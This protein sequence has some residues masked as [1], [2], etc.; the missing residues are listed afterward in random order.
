[1]SYLYIA[2]IIGSCPLGFFIG[3]LIPKVKK[4]RWLILFSGIYFCLATYLIP[5]IIAYLGV[6]LLYIGGNL[7]GFLS[8]INIE[9]SP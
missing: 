9:R 7:L 6:V 1:M 3:R 5:G 2:F 4:I 8:T